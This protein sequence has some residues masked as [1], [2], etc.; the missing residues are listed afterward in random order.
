MGRIHPQAVG[1]HS[2]G[3]FQIRVSLESYADLVPWLMLNRGPFG[4]LVH[5]ETGDDLADHT[6]HALL[7]GPALPLRLD[8]FREAL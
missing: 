4:V 6:D 7:L 2:A 5:P 8:R 3:R 1:P